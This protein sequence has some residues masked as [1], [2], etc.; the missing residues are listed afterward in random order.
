MRNLVEAP[1]NVSVMDAIKVATVVA[2][3][4]AIRIAA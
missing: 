2:I 3:M 1:K 4:V